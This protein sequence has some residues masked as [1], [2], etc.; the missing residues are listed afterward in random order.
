MIVYG[1]FVEKAQAV[2]RD[3][4]IRGRW[5]DVN[6]IGSPGYAAEA[7]DWCLSDYQA[8]FILFIPWSQNRLFDEPGDFV[9]GSAWQHMQ[10]PIR[11][12]R[13]M[14]I[15]H[16]CSHIQLDD[17]PWS[18]LSGWGDPRHAAAWP[19]F[20]GKAPSECWAARFQ[21]AEQLTER[22]RDLRAIWSTVHGTPCPPIGIAESGGVVPPVVST[23]DWW[24]LNIYVGSGYLPTPQAVQ[25][26]YA[27]A[28]AFT[29]LPIMPVLPTFTERGAAPANFDT[30][31]QTYAEPFTVHGRS[32]PAILEHPQTWAAG[33]FC[34][35]RP[36][37][38][39]A[40]H[41]DG[42]GLTRLPRH[43]W[44]VRALTSALRSR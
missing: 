8:R 25:H 30:L 40:A 35:R 3:L 23:Q 33:V 9:G 18:R 14:G 17:E 6:Q 39:D 21:L 20:T 5:I 36:S 43:Q 4:G 28:W 24:G 34:V 29:P 26:I 13:D 10:V 41:G 1:H 16:Q 37:Q 7:V 42:V 11:W 12:L 19:M 2:A 27:Q 31:M 15:A 22:I 44:F 32:Y 38:D